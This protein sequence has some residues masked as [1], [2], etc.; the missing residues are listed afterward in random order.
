MI[1]PQDCTGVFRGILGVKNSSWEFFQFARVF[2]D[3]PPPLNFPVHTK[4]F[5]PFEKFLD[6]PLQGCIQKFLKRGVK[7]VCMDEKI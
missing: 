4:I 6:T 2:Q 5:N 7:L 3:A 1:M